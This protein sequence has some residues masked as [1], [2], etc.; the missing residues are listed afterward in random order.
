MDIR[1]I[2]IRSL[3]LLGVVMSLQSCTSLILKE[4]SDFIKVNGTHFELS[5]K[6][7]YFTGTNLWYGCYLGSTGSSGNRKRLIRELDRLKAIGVSNLRI[8]GAS[9]NSYFKNEVEPAIQIKPGVYDDSLLIGM[10]FLL[11]EMKKKGMHAVIFLNNY[12]NWT[13]GMCQYNAWA[14]N[15]KIV[16]EGK[17]YGPLMD[18]AASFYGNL[19]A[20]ELYIKYIYSIITRIN[21]YTGVQY[22][23]DPTIMA[24]QL[25]NEPRPG[26]N[27]YWEFDYYRWIETT[28]QFIHNID[29]NHLVSTGSE[30]VIGSLQDSSIYLKAHKTKYV[31]YL[32]FHLWP[33]NWGWFDAKKANTTFSN[34]EK[35]AAIYIDEHIKFAKEL[36]KPIVMEEFGLP[37]DSE[38]CKAGTPTS[39]RDKY[40]KKILALVYDSAAAGTPMAGTNFWAWA[41]EGRNKNPDNVWRK[42]DPY[43]GDPPQE[44]Q[45]LNSIYD[46]DSS[47]IDIIKLNSSSMNALDNKSFIKDVKRITSN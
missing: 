1:N 10:V 18:Y 24:W 47:T 12:W 9:E 7:Y 21:T 28:A 14:G 4:N 13:G 6:P 27:N 5:G 37:R 23:N 43:V 20:Q 15:S 42:G 33:K 32:T 19:K 17:D 25:A 30:G 26:R 46:S 35:K 2:K 39:I 34:A 44:P 29:H 31:D 40:Y 11:S 38:F 8:L 45:G 36:N 41:G 22:C 3:L 16:K